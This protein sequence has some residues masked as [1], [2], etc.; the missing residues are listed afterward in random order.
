MA[1]LQRTLSSVCHRNF[2]EGKFGLNKL[3]DIAMLR[4]SAVLVIKWMIA[5]FIE[6]QNLPASE[7]NLKMTLINLVQKICSKNDIQWFR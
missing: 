2:T 3:E 7:K 1:S 6:K 4:L 5:I